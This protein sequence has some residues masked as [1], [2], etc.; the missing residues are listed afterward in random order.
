MNQDAANPE[1]VNAR[2]REDW[3]YLPDGRWIERIVSTNNGSAYYPA[4]TNRYVWDGKVLLAV[5]DHTNG[6]VMS[7]MRGLD[8]SG[9][10]QGAGGVGG[11]LAVTFAPSNLHPS[12]SSHFVSYDG[13]GNVIALTDSTTGDSSAVFEYGPFGELLRATG[14]MSDQMPL[15]FSTMFADDVTGDVKYLYRD[16]STPEGR[17]TSRDPIEERGGENVYCFVQNEP[18]RS[19]DVFG[20]KRKVVGHLYRNSSFGDLFSLVGH[21]SMKLFGRDYGFGPAPG[22]GFIWA[23]GDTSSR[24]GPDKSL[25]YPAMVW[26]LHVRRWGN[27]WQ[28]GGKCCDATEG[29]ILECADHYAKKWHNTTYSFPFRTCRHYL[30]AIVSNCC[31]DTG[32]FFRVLFAKPE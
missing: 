14:P 29:R 6:L 20:L 16:L 32:I 11:V 17:W 26:D 8:L 2:K 18:C 1:C 23:K 31:L 21:E 28:T 4:F 7:F 25:V 12:P 19:T 5:L 15:R 13:N 22:E 9:S 30:L 24:W 27:F 3:T 10:V